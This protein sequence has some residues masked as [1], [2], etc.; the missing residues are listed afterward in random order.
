MHP[1]I[2]SQL[3]AARHQEM[4]AQAEQQ[5]LVRQAI[6]QARA[7]QRAERPQRQVRRA[8]RLVLRRPAGLEH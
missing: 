4:L 7:L 5:R 8:A 3:A 1:L 2:T 6:A